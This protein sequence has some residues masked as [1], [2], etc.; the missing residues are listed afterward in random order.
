MFCNCWSRNSGSSFSFTKNRKIMYKKR[1]KDIEEIKEDYKKDTLITFNEDQKKS[2]PQIIE[3]LFSKE[4]TNFELALEL[5][6]G[7]EIYDYL[8]D[9][10]GFYYQIIND[11][12][13]QV[14]QLQH[15]YTIEYNKKYKTKYNVVINK[16]IEELHEIEDYTW[17]LLSNFGNHVR[18]YYKENND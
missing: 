5:S 6:K 9:S 3:L 11:Y 2:F 7:L 4:K 1:Y 13:K 17:Y 16:R 10:F 18:Q 8:I 12:R 15:E 14:R